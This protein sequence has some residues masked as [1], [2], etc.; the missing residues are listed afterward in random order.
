MPCRLNPEARGK[1]YAYEALSMS[2]DYGFN[3]LG[4]EVVEIA[5]RDENL[6][7][8]GLMDKKFGWK[9]KRIQ[10]TRFGNDWLWSIGKEEWKECRASRYGAA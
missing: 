10:D 4:L 7:M 6:A 2:I 1:G 5:A 9:A 3:V 8:R